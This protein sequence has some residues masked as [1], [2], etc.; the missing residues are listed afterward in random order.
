M[1]RKFKRRNL[2]RVIGSESS[3]T[4]SLSWHS[5]QSASVSAGPPSW[6]TTL[7]SC[8][9]TTPSPSLLCSQ[10]SFSF[11]CSHFLTLS[12]SSL[13]SKISVMSWQL[14]YVF[15]KFEA[16]IW[17]FETLASWHQVSPVWVSATFTVQYVL[18]H[19]SARVLQWALQTFCDLRRC[20]LIIVCVYLISTGVT[21]K[22]HN[23]GHP[24]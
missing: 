16:F 17:N 2:W 6:H 7:W 15:G 18:T 3:P 9:P 1:S 10:P 4:V 11:T 5:L 13:P 8:I 12:F 14:F 21:R 24:L 19:L 22:F 23:L 20:C